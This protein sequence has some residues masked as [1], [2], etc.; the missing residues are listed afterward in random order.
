MTE[1]RYQLKQ[2]QLYYPD[3]SPKPNFY[4]D[5]IDTANNVELIF[6]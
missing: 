5:L 3:G 1:K 2:D 6:R 4:S